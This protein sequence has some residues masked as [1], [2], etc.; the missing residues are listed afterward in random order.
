MPKV[1]ARFI[2]KMPL[3][4]F[5]DTGLTAYLLKWGNPEALERGA[6]SGAFFE[7]YVFSERPGIIKYLFWLIAVESSKA[8]YTC[9]NLE[10]AD[11]P[12]EMCHCWLES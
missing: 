1:R 12:K 9:I 8:V 2:V 6:M 7:S 3:I 11:A 10:E 5:L 4:H